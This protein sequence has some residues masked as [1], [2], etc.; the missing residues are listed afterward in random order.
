MRRKYQKNS[1]RSP[2]WCLLALLLLLSIPVF[3]A[4]QGSGQGEKA[5]DETCAGCHDEVVANFASTVHGTYAKTEGYLCESCHGPGARHAEEGDPE[6]IYNP[7]TDYMATT[8]NTCLS[9]HQGGQ[10]ES[11]TASAH[12]EVANG[13]SD[14]HKV[15]SNRKMLLK[16]TGSALCLDC[17]QE[18]GAKFLLTSHHPVREGLMECQSC[19]EVHGAEAKH[20]FDDSGRELCVSCHTEQEGPFIYEH[21]PVNEDCGICH[22]PHGAI[23][24][25]LLVQNEPA[26]CMSCHPMHFH[27][28]LAGFD[29]NFTNPLHE[30]RGGL[31]T[32]DGFKKSMLTKC[33]QCHIAVH[34]SD[35][36]SQSTSSQGKS[37]TR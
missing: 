2:V 16:K 3:L 31:S 7:A 21:Q 36:S 37:L 15:H 14:C 19:H 27:T 17:H 5:G 10:F 32:K 33:T 8:E 29:G 34:G 9:C 26:L 13:C 30:E 23:A 25:N 11:A 4:A 22:D 18:I 28:S 1:A 35:L 24:D 12:H 20:A 6:L